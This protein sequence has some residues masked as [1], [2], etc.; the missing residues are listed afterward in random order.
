[1]DW[2]GWIGKRIFVKLKSGGFVS[3]VV[4]STDGIFIHVIDKFDRP[5]T[6]AVDDII[7]IEEE[8]DL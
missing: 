8:S 3:G 4:K 6:F 5:V 1:M 2:L 7:K